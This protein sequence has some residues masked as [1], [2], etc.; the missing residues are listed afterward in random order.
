VRKCKKKPR[1]ISLLYHSI[2]YSCKAVCLAAYLPAA[3]AV[4]VLDRIDPMSV[5]DWR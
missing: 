5:E 2:W 1:R 3:V 4:Y